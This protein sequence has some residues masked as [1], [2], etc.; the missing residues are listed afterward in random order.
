MRRLRSR[1]LTPSFDLSTGRDRTAAG[2]GGSVPVPSPST[3]EKETVAGAM[4]DSPHL[5]RSLY[6]MGQANWLEL[7]PS[8]R[9]IMKSQ[10][11]SQLERAKTCLA[12]G[13]SFRSASGIPIMSPNDSRRRIH[14]K[15]NTGLR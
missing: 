9:L 1:F 11:C 3:Q 4:A 15:L 2:L 8:A 10:L 6:T 5:V 12:R 7:T 13:L 14:K